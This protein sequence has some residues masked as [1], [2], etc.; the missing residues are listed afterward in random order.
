M[1]FDDGI[2]ADLARRDFTVN[3]IAVN[4]ETGAL[5]DPFHGRQDLAAKTLRA[6]GNPFERFSEDGLR[7]LR[8]ARFCAVL[9]FEL[10]PATFA[11]IAP[12]LP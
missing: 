12:T 1:H 6:V 9:E 4:P 3:A 5:V 11:A 10:E 8:A 7:V 2:V